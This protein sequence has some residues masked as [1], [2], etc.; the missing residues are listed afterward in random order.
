MTEKRNEKTLK[1]GIDASRNRSG[2]AKAHLI[3]ILAEF[4]PFKYGIIE[5]HVW[6]FRSL[7]ALLPDRSWLIKH[8]PVELEQ[9][10]F[11]QLWWQAFS[12][13]DELKTAG[14]DI[15]FTTD[16]STLCSFKPNVVL[17]QDLLSYEPGM[18]RYYG[19]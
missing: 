6:S 13:S 4:D 9:S 8:S 14:C 12:L 5:V 17:S 18:M 2:G 7:L 10:L 19:F 1:I 11:K 16:A 15:L 3:G